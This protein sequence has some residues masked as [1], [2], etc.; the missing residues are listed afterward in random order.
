MYFHIPHVCLYHLY[1]ITARSMVIF[2]VERTEVDLPP[3]APEKTGDLEGTGSRL[4]NEKG[5]FI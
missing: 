5:W 1:T 4:G 3:L 2:Q